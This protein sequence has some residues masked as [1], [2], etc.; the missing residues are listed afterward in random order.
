MGPTHMTKH[1]GRAVPNAASETLARAAHL[2]YVLGLTQA[3]VAKRLSITRFK[4]HRLLAQAR[5][6]GMVRI[7]I[8]VPFAE[9]LEL[10]AALMERYGLTAAFVCPSD[11]TEDMPLPIVI[12]Q[13]ASGI[14]NDL[15]RDGQTVATSW[16][17]TLL[18]LARSIDP[19]AVQQL[20][21]VSMI[22]SLS[23]RSS[24]DKYEAASVL[25]DRI[26]AECFYLPGPILCDNVDAKKAIESQP[27]VQT[28]MKKA[29][30]AD[31][32]LL[33]IGG[34]EMSSL[35]LAGVASEADYDS[36]TKAGAIGNF[37]GRFIGKDGAVIDHPLNALCLGIGP[38]DIRQIP[39]RV[40]C[41]GG[42]HKV[43]A[44]GA[45]LRREA[46]TILVTDEDTAKALT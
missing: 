34:S 38:E 30:E 23:T 32:A 31:V 26:G 20:S 22:G 15:L 7:E 46:A 5:E 10:E 14:V 25:A 35:R 44:I 17:S 8:D 29:K 24:Q 11:E 1:W 21:V 13:Y 9:R 3:E 42:K 40:L 36:A 19:G 12:G 18:A 41:A 27:V 33:S 28:A 6:T 45:V 37:L 4:V 2:Y 43:A 16:G 39:V